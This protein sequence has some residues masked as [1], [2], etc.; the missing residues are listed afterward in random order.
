MKLGTIGLVV[1]I[2]GFVIAVAVFAAVFLLVVKKEP[3]GSRSKGAISAVIGEIRKAREA[4]QEEQRIYESGSEAEAYIIEVR[5]TGYATKRY[6]EL[7]LTLEVVPANGESFRVQTR[8]LISQTHIA[9]F[10][11]GAKLKVKYDPADKTKIVLV[12]SPVLSEGRKSDITHRLEELEALREKGL[13]SEDEY[14][15]KRQEILNSL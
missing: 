9:L 7:L 6:T 13:I 14:K 12:S 10:Q 2:V 8:E 3:S 4:S 5:D 1:G 15:K 11:P